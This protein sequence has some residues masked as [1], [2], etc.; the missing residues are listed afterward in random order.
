M[1]RLWL[2]AFLGILFAACGVR[3]PLTDDVNNGDGGINGAS[4]IYD[5]SGNCRLEENHVVGNNNLGIKAS[6]DTAIFRNTLSANLITNLSV[7]FSDLG[8][9]NNPAS[10]A[11]S[12]WSNIAH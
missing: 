3:S 10:T 7:S 2:L 9:I 1:K 11:T 12:P 4:G 8:P 5:V 6:G